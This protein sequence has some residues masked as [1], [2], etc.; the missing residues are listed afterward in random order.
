MGCDFGHLLILN[1]KLRFLSAAV[2]NGNK[3]GIIEATL[4]VGLSREE[5]KDDLAALIKKFAE[6]LTSGCDCP[7]TFHFV[8]MGEHKMSDE[9]YVK[10]NARGKTL[11]PFENFKAS[12]EQ[13]LEEKSKKGKKQCN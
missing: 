5:L 2:G 9:T 1:G 11:T 10:M 3:L 12:L 7:I 4:S 6:K 8:D 13:Y